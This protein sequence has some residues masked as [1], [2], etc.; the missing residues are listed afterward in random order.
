VAKKL[1]DPPA[2]GKQVLIPEEMSQTVLTNKKQE[3]LDKVHASNIIKPTQTHIDRGKYTF[4]VIK[5]LE[6]PT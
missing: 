1:Q 5:S 4:C 3:N 6:D 2:Y